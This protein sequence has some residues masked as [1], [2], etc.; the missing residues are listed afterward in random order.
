VNLVRAEI[1][2]AIL[3]GLGVSGEHGFEFP[4]QAFAKLVVGQPWLLAVSNSIEAVF[5]D[6]G[7]HEPVF[8]VDDEV[9][10]DPAEFGEVVVRLEES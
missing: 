2:D 3:L 9:G 5:A 10:I 1:D 4:G 8:R 6:P 7:C